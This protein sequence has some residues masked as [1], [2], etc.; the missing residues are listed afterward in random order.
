MNS[1]YAAGFDLGTT[2]TA[3][4]IARDGRTEMIN[5]GADAAAIPSV[6]HLK[7]DLSITAGRPALQRALT[8]PDRIARAFKRR[9]GD[10]APIMVGGTPFAAHT[11]MGRLLEWAH[12]VVTEREG[13]APGAVG[14]THPANWGPYKREILQQVI[15][16]ADL[17]TAVTVSEPEAAA[18]AYASANRV[19]PGD[20]IAVYDLGGGTFD[21]AVLR[22]TADGFEILGTPTGVEALGGVDFDEAVWHHVLES[23]PEDVADLDMTDP[24]VAVTVNELRERCTEA[25]IALSSDT[26]T[27]I[28]VVLPQVHTQIRITRA[29]FEERIRPLID[30]TVSCVSRALR[31]A[32]VEPQDL[33]RVLLVGGSSRIPLVGQMV[34]ESMQRPVA[35]DSDPKNAIATGAALFAADQLPAALP[36]AASAASLPDLS[37][38]APPVAPPTPPPAAAPTEPPPSAPPAAPPTPPPAAPVADAPTQPVPVP[39]AVAA[40][41]PPPVGDPPKKGGRPAWLLPLAGVVVALAAIGGVVAAL[42]GGGGDDS[43][44][45]TATPVP[46]EDASGDDGDDGGQPAT[47]IGSMPDREQVFD[48]L[49]AQGFSNVEAACAVEAAELNDI[50]G[51]VLTGEAEASIE[52]TLTLDDIARD[53][54]DTTD[55]GLD[56]PSDEVIDITTFGDVNASSSFESTP[57]VLAVDGDVGT[58]WFADFAA[59]DDAPAQFVWIAASPVFIDSIAVVGNAD[60]VNEENREGFGFELVLVTV[61]DNGTIVFE[62]LF[63]LSGTPDPTVEVSPSVQ[64]TEVILSF[65][66]DECACGGGFAE[67]V[68]AGFVL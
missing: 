39:Q 30:E 53:C 35:V 26:D 43:A 38:S 17:H 62:E 22:R 66:G 19:D 40:P 27:V 20:T 1:G 25:K 28:P 64:G 57:E 37:P 13:G 12:G 6:I 60:N 18:I 10:P 33:S 36:A 44:T 46:T 8:E 68:V 7:E 52:E 48:T 21:A 61:S 24:A 54:V 14:V 49:V 59:E 50:S 42:S 67:L 63:D 16:A 11:L 55:L 3:A 47:G 5:L 15:E 9:L 51:P 45:P 4:A 58:S 2:Y 41:T 34:S 29:E 32:D 56:T 23:L 31:S 65:T